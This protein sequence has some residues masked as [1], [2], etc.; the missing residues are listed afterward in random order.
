MQITI[1]CIII[2]IATTTIYFLSEI[3]M[4]YGRIKFNENCIEDL[5]MQFQKLNN[6]FNVGD[7]NGS[8]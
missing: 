5:D 2:I 8:N 4:I 7:T 1:F 3:A 6:K